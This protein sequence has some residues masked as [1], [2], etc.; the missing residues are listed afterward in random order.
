MDQHINIHPDHIV[1]RAKEVLFSRLDDELL[2]I[3]AQ[4]GFCYALN[5]VRSGPKLE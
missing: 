5:G 4:A 1:Q 3:D 2:A